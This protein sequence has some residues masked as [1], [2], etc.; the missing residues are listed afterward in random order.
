MD[1]TEEIKK[2]IDIV[3][4]IGGYVP[5]KKAGVNH[6][7]LCPF[8]KEDTPSFM[9]SP[10]KQIWHCFGCSEGGDIFT[11]VQKIDGLDFPDALKLLADRA[12]VKLKR[13]DAKLGR[14]KTKLSDINEAAANLYHQILLR[15]KAG[16]KARDYLKKRAIK[17]QTIRDFQIGYAPN[18]W[19]ATHKALTSKKNFKPEEI[20]RAGLAIRSIKRSAKSPFY[21]RFRGRIMFPIRNIAGTVVGFSGRILDPD[22]EA[23]KYINTPDTPIYNK[24][25]II[26][27]LDRARQTIREKKFV[28]IVEGQMDV[29]T[30]HQAGF[31]FVVA[32]SG[33]AL[34]PG[35][36]QLLKKYT[37]NIAF[38]F[39]TDK[40]GTA[41]AKRAIDV[42]NEAEVNAKLVILPAGEDPD[43]LIRKD[44]K[45]F[46]EVIKSAKNA[47]EFYLI[48]AFA[49]RPKTLSIEDKREISKELLPIIKNIADPVIRGEYMQKLA[50]KLGTDE[51]YLSEALDRLAEKREY[52]S[53]KK[54]IKPQPTKET[55]E[56]RV[57]VAILSY[58]ELSKKFIK[59]LTLADFA[60]ENA[61]SVYSQIKKLYNKTKK[62]VWQKIKGKITAAYAGRFNVLLLKIEEEFSDLTDKEIYQEIGLSV[63]RLKSIKSDQVKRD[64]EEKI[65]A[66]EAEGDQ[67]KIK[68][69]IKDFQ[70]K[71]IDQGRQSAET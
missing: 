62:V 55:L 67:E 7:A 4:L 9:V 43:S 6:K 70:K 34:T 15:S 11:F 48:S 22:A 47:V 23:A 41:A 29:V 26:F 32:T 58:P 5:L 64:F 21:D 49:D 14:Q 3:D 46:V 38:A 57:I 71:I 37:E 2:R 35:H 54:D 31:N 45:K 25:Q 53:L 1:D 17:D 28:V 12:G 50:S 36:I 60:D 61:K 39:D 13:L 59:K 65:R 69:L 30:A 18:N 40:A 8:H 10:E 63:N 52:R 19:E 33:T 42:A 24:S 56:E 20:E 27:G 44:R 68:K 66:A 16:A 51:K